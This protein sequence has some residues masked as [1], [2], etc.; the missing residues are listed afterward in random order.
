MAVVVLFPYD[1]LFGVFIRPLSSRPQNFSCE[2][3]PPPVL[4]DQAFQPSFSFIGISILPPRCLPVSPGSHPDLLE[5]CPLCF[6][7]PST[8]RSLILF[9]QQAEGPSCPFDSAFSSFR[10]ALCSW[11]VLCIFCGNTVEGPLFPD[12][13]PLPGT[14]LSCPRMSPTTYPFPCCCQPPRSELSCCDRQVSQ[15][16]L[17]NSCLSRQRL[18]GYSSLPGTPFLTPSIRIRRRGFP[19]YL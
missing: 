8:L 17:G 4:F 19:S 12:L 13:C 18:P 5:P 15:L 7:L 14:A 2:T 9:H 6:L 16:S 11:I 10:S 1:V 3:Y